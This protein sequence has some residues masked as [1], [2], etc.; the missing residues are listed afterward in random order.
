MS[1]GWTTRNRSSAG[2]ADPA[3]GNGSGTLVSILLGNGDGTFQPHVDYATGVGAYSVAVGD[4]NGDGKLDLAISN[5][6]CPGANCVPASISI[7]LGNGD[8]TFQTHQDYSLNGKAPTSILTADFN[9]DIATQVVD[10][11]LVFVGPELLG[12]RLVAD[13]PD[14]V[15]APVAP[16]PVGSQRQVGLC[17]A[18]RR[19][20]A[21]FRG[22]PRP[23]GRQQGG[24]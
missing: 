9:A 23:I 14:P 15:E 19:V 7:L 3:Q 18:C 17:R 21:A 8:G 2:S 12:F 24:L 6:D 22:R 4:F 16:V 20:V 13:Q 10:A 1:A 11:V 5:E